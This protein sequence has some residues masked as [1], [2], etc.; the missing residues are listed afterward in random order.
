M[1]RVLKLTGGRGETQ[2][3]Y[4]P[5]FQGEVSFAVWSDSYSSRF[6]TFGGIRVIFPQATDLEISAVPAK[7]TYRPGEKASVS[8]SLKSASG[9]PVESA[10]GIA[11]VDQAVFERVRTDSEFGARH[12]FYCSYCSY[13]G[14]SEVG[15]VRLNDL[16][17]LDMKKPV[18]EGL[19][20]VAE[21]LLAGSYYGPR[22]EDS[23]D[24]VSD[25]A[26]TYAEVLNREFKETKPALDREQKKESRYPRSVAELESVLDA[27]GIRLE[28]LRDPWGGSFEAGFRIVGNNDVI[29]LTSA[30]PDKRR[31]TADDFVALRVQKA[32]FY[33]QAA[34]I[35]RILRA[36]EYPA[37]ACGVPCIA[38]GAR[39]ELGGGSRSLGQRIP[40][41][42]KHSAG[43][44]VDRCCLCSDR[45]D[46]S[47]HGTT[48]TSPIFRAATSG[49][50]KRKSARPC[51]GRRASR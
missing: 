26:S 29:E 20:L 5:E 22:T 19:D 43:A 39:Y 38:V 2:F 21:M 7:T 12:W 41:Q 28:E 49:A 17:N 10:L 44:K 4:Q 1:T 11:A 33:P 14:E 3:A 30:G 50:R 40:G 35:H 45:T 13:A 42:C 48:C 47:T 6:G 31:G 16:H 34:S 36:G 15:G 46:S 18:P 32:F 27:S 37:D 25:L 24:F 23:G 9:K 8:F 51:S